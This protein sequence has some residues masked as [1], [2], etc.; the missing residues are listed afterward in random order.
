MADGCW[1]MGHVA[2]SHAQNHAVPRAHGSA[3]ARPDL[4]PLGG[5]SGRERVRAA[6]RSRVRR[7][8]ERG[9]AVRRLAA[10]QVP[11]HAAA[12]RRG[13]STAWSRA[14]SRSARSA[15][16]CTR[17]GATRTARSSTTARSAASTTRTYR[18]T[19][20]E[21]NLRW[22]SMNAVGLDVDDRGRLRRGPARSRCRGRSRARSSQQL[23]AGRPRR[24]SSTSGSCTRR[25]R[26]IPVTISRTGYTGDLGYEIWVDAERAVALWDALIEA[27]TATASRRRASGRS[28]SRA[29]RPASSCSTSTTS[30]R[31]TR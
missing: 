31:I 17:R 16:C 30:R 14:T 4:A 28:T 23:I 10:L 27:G 20:A 24:R 9:G 6:P 7:H 29:S 12:T 5:L 8:P 22:L 1:L 25:V 2:L 15:R 3:R 18:L 11:D 21:P 26:D 19:S 13:C